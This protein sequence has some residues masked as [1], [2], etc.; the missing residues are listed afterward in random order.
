[1]RPRPH[2]TVL[3]VGTSTLALACFTWSCSNKTAI[4]PATDPEARTVPAL[5]VGGSSLAA[6]FVG[7]RECAE[8]HGA[9]FTAHADSL[10]AHTLR[11]ANIPE[12]VQLFRTG[13]KL[14]DH[15]RNVS[16]EPVLDGGEPAFAIMARSSGVRRLVKPVYVVGSGRF[17]YT[18][19]LRRGREFIESRLSY[20]PTSGEWV[21]TPGQEWLAPSQPDE[22]RVQDPMSARKCLGCHS[23]MVFGEG[24]T[25]DSERSIL[26]I[27]CERCHGPG[28]EHVEEASRGV[29]EP[30]G[31]YRYTSASA[32]TLMRLCSECHRGPGTA[33]GDALE[34]DPALPRFAGTALAASRCYTSSGGRMSCLSCHDPHL[35][36]S[37]D[38]SAYVRACQKCHDG[39]E[40]N[41]RVCPV[42]Q[43][44]GC[45]RCHMPASTAGFGAKNLF[46][47]HWIKTYPVDP[48]PN[49]NPGGARRS[50]FKAQSSDRKTP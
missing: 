9:Q 2:I 41:W 4:E 45:I 19:L 21:W 20:F 32:G 44:D 42:N 25:L 33:P 17:G 10:H 6:K 49:P 29:K 8:C 12:V 18:F 22:G 15:E 40:G 46:H 34:R 37:R 11:P 47:N 24:Q 39:K 36:V 28:R 31:I 27:G 35:K 14:L 50:G 1:M 43:T 48:N 23:T 13:R 3:A 7:A 16:Y 38:T 5:A 30:G 26:D